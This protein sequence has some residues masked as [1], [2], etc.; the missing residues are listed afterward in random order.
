MIGLQQIHGL[1]CGRLMRVQ[2][3]CLVSTSFL[4][5]SICLPHVPAWAIGHALELQHHPTV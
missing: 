2:Q 3:S 5:W 4:H 1:H